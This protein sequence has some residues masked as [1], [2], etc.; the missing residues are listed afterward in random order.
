MSWGNVG[1]RASPWGCRKH[2]SEPW[3]SSK[4]PF[5]PKSTVGLEVTEPELCTGEWLYLKRCPWKLCLIL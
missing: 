4:G 3:F 2:S 5:A 1:C